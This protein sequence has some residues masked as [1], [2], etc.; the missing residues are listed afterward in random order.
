MGWDAARGLFI[1]KRFLFR[2]D[3]SPQ[4]GFGHFKRCLTLANE[5]EKKG[6]AIF[7]LIRMDEN[8]MPGHPDVE[9]YL[10]EPL[11]WHLSPEREV[12]KLIQACRKLNIDAAIIDHYHA[13]IHYQ[14][15]L[16]GAGVK[17]L[18]FD[19]YARF[20]LLADWILCPS[21]AGDEKAYR[22]MM[23]RRE[24]R[25]LLGPNYAFLRPEF[26]LWQPKVKRNRQVKKILLSFGGGDDRGATLF[27]LESLRRLTR[28]IDRIVLVSSGNPQMPCIV[29]WCKNNGKNNTTV[30]IDEP[31]IA[32]VMCHADLAIT[33]GGMT[34]FETAA[35]QLP[36]LIVT[37]AENQIP[38]TDAWHQSGTAVKLGS[39]DDLKPSEIRCQVESLVSDNKKRSEMSE[40]GFSMVDCRGAERVAKLLLSSNS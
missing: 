8:T 15:K 7:F 29:D 25:L 14:E 31:E 13:D 9:K 12:E 3:V 37:I 33:A 17:W 35:M 39:I 21:L 11:G 2:F 5:L 1:I 36:T 28:E 32:R 24:S 26:A 16:Y 34:T 23:R 40:K 19:R 20:P 27:C 22:A 4:I 10:L 38:N 6:A 18:Q 30:R